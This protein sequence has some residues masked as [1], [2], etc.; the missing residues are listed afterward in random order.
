MHKLPSVCHTDKL[1]VRSPRRG[2]RS[3]RWDILEDFTTVRPEPPLTYCCSLPH[4][5]ALLCPSM[6]PLEH[7]TSM[8]HG[9]YRVDSGT[10][11]C[12]GLQQPYTLLRIRV[13]AIICPNRAFAN[14]ILSVPWL[15]PAVLAHCHTPLVLS[16]PHG[17]HSPLLLLFCP[18]S[19]HPP[20]LLIL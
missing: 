7:V 15:C 14:W 5:A 18:I 20:F 13:K 3:P 16:C 17:P 9:K 2:Y 4:P 10:L 8:D 11:G 19:T 6:P 1:W 12:Q